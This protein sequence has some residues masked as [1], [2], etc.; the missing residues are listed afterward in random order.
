MDGMTVCVGPPD[1]AWQMQDPKDVQRKFCR[2]RG[3][4]DK[5]GK[6]Q[7]SASKGKKAFGMAAG[8]KRESVAVWQC[9]KLPWHGE[10]HRSGERM[11]LIVQTFHFIFITKVWETT[12]PLHSGQSNTTLK[13]ITKAGTRHKEVGEVSMRGTVHLHVAGVADTAFV[14]R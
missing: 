2:E 13:T 8:K 5:S 3:G 4:G 1:Q 12:N 7:G 9:S 6:K 11:I 14:C 10:V